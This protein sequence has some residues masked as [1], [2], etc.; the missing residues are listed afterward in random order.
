VQRYGPAWSKRDDFVN[1]KLV[2]P[3]SWDSPSSIEEEYPMPDGK[4]S[5]DFLNDEL[6]PGTP[7]DDSF[8]EALMGSEDEFLREVSSK[9]GKK[10]RS[11]MPPANHRVLDHFCSE[12]SC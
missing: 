9:G 10:S 12:V 7:D 6:P 3:F 4:D 1:L 11:G 2:D 5:L 8:W